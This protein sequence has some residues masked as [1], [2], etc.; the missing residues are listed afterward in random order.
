MSDDVIKIRGAREH[1]LKNLTLEIPRNKMVV[2]TGLSGS[3]KSSLAFNTI[4]AEGQRRYVESL[5]AYA[6]QF[7]ELMEKPDVDLIEGLSPAIAIEQRTPSHNPRST[8]GTVTEIYDYLRLLYARVG[9]PHCPDCGREIEPRSATQIIGDIL[10][11]FDGQNVQILAPLV[12]G[13]TGTYEALFDKLK[14]SGFARVRVNNELR[15]LEKKIALDRYKKHTIEAVVDRLAVAAAGRTRLADSVETALRESRG[16]LVVAPADGKGPDRLFSEHHACPHCGTSLPEIEPRLFSFN[17]PYG[18]C[19]NCDGLGVKL[20]V[21]EDLVVTDESLSIADGALSAWADPVTTRTNRWKKSWSGYYMEILEEVCRRN[22]IPLDK[23]W[24]SLLPAQRKSLLHGGMDHKSPWGKNVK[25]FEGVIGNLERRYKESESAFVKEEIQAR[26]MRS[27]LCPDCKGARLKPEALAVTVGGKSIAQ[28]TRLS[29]QEAHAFFNALPLSEKSQFVARQ[30]LK[31]IRSRL[32]FLVDV[33]LEY[34]NLDR[35]SATLAGGEAQRI[36]LATQIGSGLVGVLYVLDEPTIGLHPRD[37]ARLLTTLNRLRDIGNTLVIVEHDEETIRAADWVIDLGPGA[38]VHGGQIIAQG[39]VKDLLKEPKSLTGAYLRGERG[40][41]VPAERRR[42]GEKFL[43]IK[44]AS[45][46]NLKN[47][48]V[49][50]PLGLFVAVTGV[51]G[52]GKSTLVNEI[53]HK[54]LAQKLHHAKDE[55]GRHRT[56]AGVENVDK[57]VDVDQTPIGRTPRSNAATYTGAFGPIRDLFAQLPEA[58]RRGYKPGR[59]SFNVKGGRCENCEG[60]GTLKISMQFLPDVYVKCDVCAGQRFNAETLEIKYKGKSI[61]EVLAMPAEEAAVFFENIPA[62]ARVLQTLVDVGMGY[63]AIG[64]PATTLSGGEAQRVKLASELCRRPTGHTLY[65]L[66]E[67]TTGLHFADVEKLLGV[68]QRLVDGGNTVLVIEHN[69]DVIK[70]ADWILDLGPEGGA[71]GGRLVAEGAPET[72]AAAADSHT[73][74][75]LGPLL[76]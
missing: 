71:G 1:N 68:L 61:A 15:D 31:E 75:H 69:L 56:L 54:A 51:S 10:K 14:K 72:V 70:T 62:V 24:R 33:G 47:I 36:H 12:R 45:Q 50:I 46:F 41:P 30:V 28:A 55:P 23:P 22:K 19:A 17:S 52:S 37:N 63:A 73:G 29:V 8:V 21:A 2:V 59:F 40:I 26:F 53:L 20:E 9:T 66:D 39:T 57:V 44:G 3:G 74:R 11:E 18:A 32:A 48:D 38:G 49:K 76:K 16:L 27:R 6:R 4:Y 25:E 43:E 60:D 35:E 7:L 58:R 13:R 34:V 5:S 65:I 42:P 67:P 64:Q